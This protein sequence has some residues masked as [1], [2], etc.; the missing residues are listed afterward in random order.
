MIVKE[1]TDKM[2]IET[3][4]K[5]IKKIKNR[6]ELS[7]MVD[8]YLIPH[9]KEKIDNAE[10][11]TPFKLRQ[12]MLDKIP[13]DFWSSPKKVFEPC[14]GKG[15]FLIDIIDKKI[16]KNNDNIAVCFKINLIGLIKWLIIFFSSKPAL[17]K[18]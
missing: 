3:F 6:K 12:E 1:L 13:E 2:D 16:K 14:C 4:S 9:E 15:G 11:T 8:K 5:F 17:F 10:F 7:K 18:A